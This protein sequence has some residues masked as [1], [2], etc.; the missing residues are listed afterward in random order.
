MSKLNDSCDI[1]FYLD[2]IFKRLTFPVGG[3]F[4][5]RK[6]SMLNLYMMKTYMCIREQLFL[7]YLSKLLFGE[8]F[9]IEPFLKVH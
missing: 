5:G 6:H 7:R 9:K 1:K 8:I 2:Y 4:L 3:S